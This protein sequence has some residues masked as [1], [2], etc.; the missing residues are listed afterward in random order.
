[1]PDVETRR[2]LAVFFVGLPAVVA[3][4][5]VAPA[6]GL[7]LARLL[8]VVAAGIAAYEVAR[9]YPPRLRGHRG[10]AVGAVALGAA[11]PIAAAL[12]QDATA[13]AATVAV[14]T[15]IVLVAQTLRRNADEFP[16]IRAI[17]ALHTALL[18]YPG[19]FAA[20]AVRITTLPS[21]TVAILLLFLGSYLNDS[22]AWLF[23]RLLARPDHRV[24]FAVSPAK[25]IPGFVGGG[26]VGIAAVVVIGRFVPDALPGGVVAH[27]AFG[28]LLALVT[29]FGDLVASALKRSA[30]VKN[31]G[32]IIPGRGGMLDSIDSPLFAAPFFY[33]AHVVL[34]G[35]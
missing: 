24:V 21:P 31:S 27:L 32:A 30:D 15:A 11:P 33:L 14:A 26:T 13:I 12:L 29:I 3:T 1:M 18:V 34:F 6:R 5:L 17:V 23:G 8:I 16:E 7:P 2:R 4:A 20:F 9:L 10:S 19:L 22:F 25:S 35:G 28:A